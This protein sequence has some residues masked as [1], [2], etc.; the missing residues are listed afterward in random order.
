MYD[1]LQWIPTFFQTVCFIYGGRHFD[2]CV[3]FL[4]AYNFLVERSVIPYIRL[5]NLHKE[6]SRASSICGDEQDHSYL[7]YFS[8]QED[9]RYQ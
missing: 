7:F 2:Q 1:R 3:I 5:I 8:T 6:V 9:E 4:I